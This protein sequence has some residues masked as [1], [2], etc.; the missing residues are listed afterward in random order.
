MSAG[1]RRVLAMVKRNLLVQM[2]NPGHWFLLIVL[3]LVDGLLFG[4]IGVAFG[5]GEAPVQLL[6]TGIML[7]HLIWQ[8]TLAG[9]ARPA[10]GGLE[11]QRDEPHRHAADRAR[12][13]GLTRH[14]R[15]VAHRRVG[16]RDR[17]GRARLLR[18]R[19]RLGGVGARARRRGPVA[20]RL[21]DHPVR[22]GADPA[23]RRQRRGVLVGHAR[24][25]DAAVGRVLPRRVPAARARG[26]RP[27]RAADPRVRRGADRSGDLDDRLGPAR[28]RGGG[29]AWSCSDWPPG[30][31][32]TS[33]AGSA[34]R[35]G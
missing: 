34:R 21:G 12:V 28:H 16:H 31:W 23:V 4:S 26:D 25:V 32:T 17:A 18:R 27:G 2:R 5:E 6:V 3:P 33:W 9:L 7:F 30:S 14:R 20:V 11:P 35:A 24:A 19:A 1:R 22:H 29:H 15:A 8:L 13:H 10:G